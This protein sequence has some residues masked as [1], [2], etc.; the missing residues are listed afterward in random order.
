M[1]WEMKATWATPQLSFF[2]LSLF[3]SRRATLKLTRTALS[4][5]NTF[6]PPVGQYA[7]ARAQP[8]QV[9][10]S[11]K[12]R[13]QNTAQQCSRIAKPWI[14]CKLSVEAPR[15]EI[16]V[17]S[18]TFSHLSTC[19]S[20]IFHVISV[21]KVKTKR[22]TEYLRVIPISNF[23]NASKWEW[24]EVRTTLNFSSFQINVNIRDY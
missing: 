16:R 2:P 23:A 14:S 6:F 5:T 11:N 21:I 1:W 20:N 12:N 8:L 17:E 3:F 13:E 9:A 18:D 24:S 22:H 7:G 19:Y 10:V 4:S 15:D